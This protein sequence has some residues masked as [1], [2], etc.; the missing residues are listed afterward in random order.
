MTSFMLVKNSL[1]S[2]FLVENHNDEDMYS[3]IYIN[4][5]FCSTRQKEVYAI[6]VECWSTGT[7]SFAPSIKTSQS[8]LVLWIVISWDD[9]AKGEITKKY[10]IHRYSSKLRNDLPW[11]NTKCKTCQYMKG[12]SPKIISYI[13]NG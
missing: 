12:R 5:M 3:W 8:P 4:S 2:E 11:Y 7:R 10:I 6:Q 1:S 9:D 13:V